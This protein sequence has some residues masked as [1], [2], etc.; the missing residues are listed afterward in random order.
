MVTPT[1]PEEDPGGCSVSHKPGEAP[2]ALYF[3]ILTL[4][5]MMRAKQRS[6]EPQTA[7]A[8]VEA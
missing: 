5:G 6:L 8:K 2:I 4:A 3:T 1:T 7:K